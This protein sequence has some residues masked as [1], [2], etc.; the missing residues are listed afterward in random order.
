[1]SPPKPPTI[2]EVA[3]AIIASMNQRREEGADARWHDATLDVVEIAELA[4]ARLG[5]QPEGDDDVEYYKMWD[6]V[7]E[8]AWQA[9][10]DRAAPYS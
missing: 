8:D 4:V 2:D 1:M 10:L 7:A 6:Q 5:R 9:I 3:D